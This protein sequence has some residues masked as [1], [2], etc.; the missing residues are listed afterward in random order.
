MRLDSVIIFLM[1][2]HTKCF[3]W[4]VNYRNTEAKIILKKQK[5]CALMHW[6]FFLLNDHTKCFIWG[7]NHRN[8]EAKRI[9]KKQKRSHSVTTPSRHRRLPM[10]SVPVSTRTGLRSHWCHQTGKDRD[11]RQYRP[12]RRGSADLNCRWQSPCDAGRIPMHG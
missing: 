3:I 11:F 4:G 2:D 1:N 7:V 5:R 6:S 9:M 12:G 8:T 10:D